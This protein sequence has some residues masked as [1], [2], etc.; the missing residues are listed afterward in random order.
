[1]CIRDSPEGDTRKA[2]ELPSFQ[3]AALAHGYPAR[4]DAAEE[5]PDTGSPGPAGGSEQ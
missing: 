3:K 1:M 4:R 5:I 2:G